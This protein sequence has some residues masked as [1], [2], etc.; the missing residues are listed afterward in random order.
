MTAT[1]QLRDE[2]EGILTM[3]GLIENIVAKPKPPTDHLQQVVEFLQVFADRC[4][5]G[6][7]EDLLFPAME[8]AGIARNNGPIGVMMME[9]QTGRSYIKAMNEALAEYKMDKTQALTVIRE[10][11]L[12]YTRLLRNHI[13]K[14]N[15]I[16]FNMADRV[17][18]DK[19]Q[20]DLLVRFD[21]V[22]NERIG[23]GR[24]EQFHRLIDELA[25]I[26]A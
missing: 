25:A 23:A 21:Q 9:H 1:R 2:H 5:H 26:Y 7:E 15:N 4:H 8:K 14:E 22:E 17:L 20:K 13:D 16:L 24:H 19:E 10:N 6:K 11:A 3:L 18:S 12:T